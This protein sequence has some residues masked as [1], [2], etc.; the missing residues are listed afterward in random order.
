MELIIAI[1]IGFLFAAGAYLILERRLLRV[2]MGASLMSH[3]VLLFLITAG[4]L[5]R[6]LAPILVEG[7]EEYV[8]AVPQALILTAIVISFA[9]TAF[10]LV[11]AYKIYHRGGKDDLEKL[12]GEVDAHDEHRNE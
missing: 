6:G 2:V 3:G 10:S 8:D 11:L 12:R 5:K 1:L 9:T 4:S 7:G